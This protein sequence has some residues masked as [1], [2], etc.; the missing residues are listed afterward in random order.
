VELDARLSYTG[1]RN[2]DYW[3]PSFI[4][5]VVELGAYKLVSFAATYR[6]NDAT[7]IYARIDNLFDTSYEDVYGYNTPGVGVY[8]GL[9]FEF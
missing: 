9:R 2:D 3:P 4:K 5:E 1:S 7:R 8:A 6:L